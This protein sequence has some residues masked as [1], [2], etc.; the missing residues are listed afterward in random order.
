M[1]WLG[2]VLLALGAALTVWSL[3]TRVRGN[4]G[5][6]IVSAIYA[7]PAG[8]AAKQYAGFAL[9]IIGGVLAAR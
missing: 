1:F 5:R 6:S 4:R 3:S 8:S 2:I 7:P 9:M